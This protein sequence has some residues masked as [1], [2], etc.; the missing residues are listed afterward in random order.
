MATATQNF[1]SNLKNSVYLTPQGLKDARNELQFLKSTK[2]LQLAKRL[3][4]AREMDNPEENAE[5]EA[6][7]TEQEFVET[8]IS[9]LEKLIRLAKIIDHASIDKSVITIGTTVM[10]EM[11]ENREKDEFT[12]VGRTE[13]NPAKKRI[14]NESPLGSA[15]LGAKVGEIVQV[16]TPLLSYSCKILEIK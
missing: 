6:A 8:K 9:E 1:N 3:Q 14:S 5:Y 4:N 2:R 15:L 11:N 12:L 13:A 7:M 16:Q 10:I